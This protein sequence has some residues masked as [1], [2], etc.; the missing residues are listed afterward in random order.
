MI[1]PHG[2]LLPIPLLVEP[3][4][5]LLLLQ[6]SLPLLLLLLLLLLLPSCCLLLWP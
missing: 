2:L 4:Q 3:T 5:D 6:L 1:Q